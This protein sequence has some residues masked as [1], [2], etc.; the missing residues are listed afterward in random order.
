MLSRSRALA[1]LGGVVAAGVAAPA[2]AQALA[3]VRIGTSLSDPFLEPFYAQEL[4]FFKDAGLAADIQPMFNGSAELAAI[5]GGSLDIGNTDLMV[6]ANAYTRGID[7]GVVASGAAYNAAQPTISLCVAKSS[8]YRTAK[9]LEGQTIAVTSL[10]SSATSSISEWLVQGGADLTKVS[11][12]EML[13]AQM[14]PA[15]A[16]GRIAAALSGEPF[17]TDEKN[18]IRRI[19]DPYSYIAKTFYT[20]VWYGKRSWLSA[21]AATAKAFVSALY[22]S[23]RWANAHQSDSA[24]IAARLNHLDVQKVRSFV[25]NTFATSLEARYA[26]PPLDLGYKYKVIDR[27]ISATD[28]FWRPPA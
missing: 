26:Q 2:T 4:G 14:G 7:I 10:K 3:P 27:Q 1:L 15:L 16:S 22:T 9:D 23:G 8:P 20:G 12:F 28:L 5:Q 24:V 19:C 18:N 6:L 13:F 17:L 21:N 11:F 25:R